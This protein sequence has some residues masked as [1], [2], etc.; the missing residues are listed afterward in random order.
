M[1]GEGLSD[2]VAVLKLAWHSAH[3]DNG[4][5]SAVAFARDDLIPAKE[6]QGKPRFVSVDEK[7]CVEQT[8]VDDRISKVGGVGHH[9]DVVDGLV[10]MT[11]DEAK[12]AFLH[13]LLRVAPEL[14]IAEVR[15]CGHLQEDLELDSME[16][17]NLVAG[18]HERFSVDMPEADYERLATPDAAA[19][20]LAER[21]D[22]GHAPAGPS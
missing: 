20:Y 22:Q 14:E 15:G 13:D 10:P 17:L 9:D 5:L 2:E 11:V 16:V 3:F 6:N 8:A 7:S 1:E 19:A 18:L 21:I 4:R 12:A